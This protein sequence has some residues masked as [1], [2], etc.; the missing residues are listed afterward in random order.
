MFRNFKHRLFEMALEKSKYQ[1]RVFF[2]MPQIVQN[3][4]LCEYCKSYDSNNENYNCW[5]KEL[6][7][8]IK[9]LKGVPVKG[10]K[11][12]WTYE[13]IIKN[14]EYNTI[15][16]VKNMCEDKLDDEEDINFTESIREHLYLSFIENIDFII[17]LIS[18]EDKVSDK[19][20]E[21][22]RI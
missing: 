14:C 12:K 11:K 16:V 21:Y 22:F 15:K 19:I 13:E 9:N 7:A 8:H 20:K 10:N 4:C 2:L 18:G 6:I 3:W 1:D 5:R 17:E